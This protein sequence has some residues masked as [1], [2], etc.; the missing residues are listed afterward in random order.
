MQGKL[1][2]PIVKRQAKKL[3]VFLAHLALEYG[4][5][6]FRFFLITLGMSFQ[7]DMSTNTMRVPYQN[8]MNNPNE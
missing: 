1:G 7:T 6:S 8:F 3:V 2:P 4:N 5:L